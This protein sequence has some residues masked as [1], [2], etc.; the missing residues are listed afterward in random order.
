MGDIKD[1]IAPRRG[2]H[3]V[4]IPAVPVGHQGNSSVSKLEA[5]IE[6]DRRDAEYVGHKRIAARFAS[7]F[8]GRFIYTVGCGWLE[9]NGSFWEECGDSQPWN[10][11]ETVCRQA[12]RDAADM[13]KADRKKLLS[14][15]NQCD[16]ASGTRSVLDHVKR[17]PGIAENDEALDA[18]PGLFALTNGVFDLYAGEFRKATPEDRLTLHG[19]VA[20]DPNAQCP[21]YDELMR[22]YQ[23]DEEIRTYL[24]RLAGAAMEGKQNLQILPIWHG[25]TAGNGKGTTERAWARV[26]GTYAQRIPVEALLAKGKYDQ[27]KDEKAKL[28][29]ARLVFTTEPSEGMRFS[30]GTVKSMTGGDPVTSREVYKSSVTFDPTWLILMSTNTRIGMPGDPGMERRIKEIHWGYTIPREEMTD[31]IEDLLASEAPGILN[32]I[33]AGWFDY[34]AN[35]IQHPEAVEKATQ[36]YFAEVDPLNQWLD[37]CTVREIDATATFANMYQSYKSWCES[38]GERFPKGARSLADALRRKGLVDSR[39]AAFRYW[40]DIRVLN[41]G[42]N[43]YTGWPNSTGGGTS[44]PEPRIVASSEEPISVVPQQTTEPGGLV[45][46]PARQPQLPTQAVI[47]QVVTEVSPQNVDM[48][49]EALKEDLQKAQSVESLKEMG[50]DIKDRFVNRSEFPFTAGQVDDLKATYRKRAQELNQRLHVPSPRTTPEQARSKVVLTLPEGSSP[51]HAQFLTAAIERKSIRTQQQCDTLAVAIGR[52][53]EIENQNTENQLAEEEVAQ[54]GT[55]LRVLAALEGSRKE[56]GPFAPRRGGRA[57]WWQ[58]PMPDAVQKTR[59]PGWNW[60]RADYAGAAIVLDRNGG[61][62]AGASSVTVVHGE[63]EHTGPIPDVSDTL[64]PGRYLVEVH[65]WYETGL[66]SPLGD[67]DPGRQIWITRGRMQ[68]LRFLAEAD[69]WP[70]ISALDSYTGKPARLASWAGYVGELRRYARENYGQKSAA[71]GAV[72]YAFGQTMGLLAGSS[73]ETG[74]GREWK[75]SKARRQDW[76]QDIEDQAAV[77]LWRV[78]DECLKLTPDTGPLALRNVDE[79]IIPESALDVVTVEH[80]GRRPAVRIDETGIKFGTFKTKA[81]QAWGV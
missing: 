46:L 15:V 53:D 22:L 75:K 4:G 56:H 77:T 43:G 58:A 5:Y 73:S 3:S 79:L 32:R 26:F 34:R 59:T 1:P 50:E 30:N 16:S 28:K 51:Q 17:W 2:G 11:V 76:K 55:T 36:E 12:I 29:G 18:H 63:L 35:G 80:D 61:W 14:I 49:Y 48:M 25:Q 65:P 7:M 10:A 68:L 72:K 57:P 45:V 13:E 67:F 47:Q 39:T 62:P 19:G 42:N 52:L 64:D 37:E 20:Y 41:D 33:L 70:D 8:T 54:A 23:P 44:V 40:K 27:Y 6:L 71:D 78:A 38:N 60:K 74:D 24:H 81:T 69:R 9:F 21:K 66:P 31:S